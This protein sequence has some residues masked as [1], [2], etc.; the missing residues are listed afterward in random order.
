MVVSTPLVWLAL[1]A[2]LLLLVLVGFDSDGL[3][4]IAAV[5]ALLLTAAVA[6]LPLPLP[7]QLLLFAGLLVAGY[8]VLRRW[9]GRQGDGRLPPSARAE[10]AEV[11]SGFEAGHPGSGSGAA[12][13][14]VRWQGQSWSALNLEPGPPLPPGSLVT[15]LGREGTQLQVLPAGPAAV[16]RRTSG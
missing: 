11:I 7:L 1:A 10:L 6:L 5:A 9:S 13:G 12:E 3:V 16:S 15:V 2:G 14:R 4:L 8:A